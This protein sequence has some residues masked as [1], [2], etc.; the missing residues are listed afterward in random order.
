MCIA[1]KALNLTVDIRVFKLYVGV[2]LVLNICFHAQNLA[3]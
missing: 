3:R 2:V 1:K